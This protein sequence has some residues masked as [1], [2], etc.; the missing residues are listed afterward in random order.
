MATIGELIINLNAN[1]A[2]FVTQLDRVK[3]LSFD[4]AKQVER[5]FALIGTAALG[6]VSVAAAAFA[7]GIQKTAEWEV[8]I[9][10][11]AQSSGMSTEALSGLSYAAKMMG[12]DIDQVAKAM[13]R[14][15]KQVVLAQAGNAKAG[16]RIGALGIDP[17]AIKTS[18]DALMKLAEHFSKMPDGIIKTGQAMNAFGKAGA[19]MVPLLNLGAKGIQDFLDEAQRMGIVITKDQAEAAESFEQNITRMK[20]S[21][22]GLWVE[23]TNAVIPALNDLIAGFRASEKESG[24]FWKSLAEYL[25]AGMEGGDSMA[26]A[27]Q[28]VDASNAEIEAHKKLMKV[29]ADADAKTGD[30]AKALDALKKSVDGMLTSLNTQIATFGQSAAAVKEYEIRTQAAKLGASAWAEAEITLYQQLTRKKAF[31]DAFAQIDNQTKAEQKLLTQ[32]AALKTLLEQIDALAKQLDLEMKLDTFSPTSNIG[33]V[34]QTQAFTDAITQQTNEVEHALAVW[35]MSADEITRYDLAQLDGSIGA[36][37]LT[38]KLIAERQ[39]LEQMQSSAAHSAM[40]WQEFGQVADRSLNDLIFSG[41]KFTQVLSDITKAL[42]EMFLKWALFGFGSNGKSGGGGGIFGMLAGGLSGLFGAGGGAPSASFADLS[43][44]GMISALPTFAAGGDVSAGAPILVGEN[45]PEIFTPSRAGVIIPNSS[46]GGNP[47]NIIYQI[48][49]RGSSITEEQF[50]RS[51]K[52]FE[53]RAVQRA[54]QA[55]QEIQLRTA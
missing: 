13:E 51:L 23:L 12:L 36:Q 50:T 5:S 25:G 42:G 22:H 4:T 10:H 45:G 44:L 35:G 53:N 21:L 29:K 33:A 47:V 49:A 46:G 27:K 28:Y 40:A 11:L 15:A 19:Q 37:K 14:F 24:S 17:A 52:L 7:V 26:L 3:N 48:D 38:D 2:S 6:M 30:S 16:Q 54:L 1:T 34:Q 31:L 55:G 43:G 18:D 9:L 20:E 41:K 32:Q 39:Q 8:H